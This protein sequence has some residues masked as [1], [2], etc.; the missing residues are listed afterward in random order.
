MKNAKLFIILMLSTFSFT[1]A[2]V[3]NGFNY[4]A[5]I[6][7]HHGIA[8]ANK[9]IKMKM[10]LLKYDANG[11]ELYSEV[12]DETTNEYG[13]INLV[14][15]HGVPINGSFSSIDWSDGPIFIETAVDTTGNSVFQTIST[16]QLLSVPFAMR[17]ETVENDLV[18]DA[19]S[20]PMNEIQNL[21][22][23]GNM[24]SIQNGNSVQLT[25]SNLWTQN[26]N[27]IFYQLGNVGI[28]T[29][30]PIYPLEI[31]NTSNITENR[32]QLVLKNK[33][34][35]SHSSAHLKLYAGSNNGTSLSIGHHSSNYTG[36]PGYH[37]ISHI[38]N[39]GRGLQLRSTGPEA[40][41]VFQTAGSEI[42]I[43][44]MRLDKYGHFGIG[45]TLPKTKLH[46]AEGDIYIEDINAGVIMKSPNGQCWRL[47]IGD[48]GEIMTETIECP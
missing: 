22:L 30:I 7:N 29:N 39:K 10:S 44:H 48:D 15:G 31:V 35:D 11:I 45:T 18:N 47:T 23:S 5:I 26:G 21:D 43:E 16:T 4:Q 25:N 8:I 46:I 24:L 19:D 1:W 12:F 27:H 40:S 41:I 38:W 42:I 17:A 9:D 14:I 2:Q 32:D 37:E 33:S 13:L 3:P 20:D 6:R 36:L 34:T 28:G